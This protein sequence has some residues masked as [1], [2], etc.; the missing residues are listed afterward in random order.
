M[1]AEF[2]TF[3]RTATGF[4]PHSYQSAL[5]AEGLPTL[6]EAPTGAGK[7]VAAVLPWLYRRLVAAPGATPRRLVFVLPRHSL[8]GQAFG[9]IGEWLERLGLT[10]EVGLHLLAG[11]AAQEGGWRRRP[12]RSAI[13]VGTHDMVLSRALM[14]GYA[15]ART[16]APVSYALLHA[17]AQWVFDEA[18][19]LGPGLST[20]RQLQLLRDELGTASATG[21]MWMSSVRGP[22]GL[23][24]RTVRAPDTTGTVRRIGRLDL[25]PG[26]YIAALAEAVTA[27]H[28]PGTRTVV[29]LNSPER[30]RAVHAGLAA[31][32]S[33]ALLLHP[34]FRAADLARVLAAAEGGHGLVLVATPALETGL[35]ISGRTLVTELAPWASLVQRAG[36]CN[37]HGEHPDGGDLLWCTPPEGGD[38]ATARWLTAHEGRAVTPGEL[39][40]ARVDTPPAPAGPGREDVLAL[41]DS[42]ADDS[43]ADDSPAA[44]TAAGVDHWIC[45]P[46]EAASLP[47][48]VAWRAL[49]CA[50]QG[51]DKSGED[52][53]GE[54]GPGED[55]PDPTGAE[56]C[57][58]PLGELRRL[59]AG[60]AWLRD[61]LDRRWRPARPEDLRPGVRLL[62]DA[63]TGGYLPDRGWTP[64][65]PA[66]VA[67]EAAASGHPAYGCT[68]W[69]GLDQHLQE[70]AQEA[71]ALLAALPAL[72]TDLWEA[73]VEAARFHDLGKCHDAFQE[74]LRAGRTDPPGGLLAK[75]KNGVGADPLPPYRSPRPHLR[76]ELVSA[77]LLWQGGHHPLVTY[78]AAAHHGHV[79]LTV[80]PRGDEAPLLLGVADGDRTPPIRLSTGEYFPART[81]HTAAFPAAW[82]ERA[83]S[84]RDTPGLGPFRLAF[85]ETLVR[86]ADWRASARHDGTLAPTTAPAG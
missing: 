51:E 1:T 61:A 15:D 28:V 41:F 35:D 82:T 76:H 54:D 52:G 22:G 64:D 21:T 75:S 73:V 16:M 7:T 58:V 8:A 38:A 49:E 44:D 42:P 55:E 11:A 9:R 81:L 14:R 10:G 84:L 78:L 70:T 83:L 69:V 31:R 32:G 86:V 50:G 26:R 4:T 12:E 79:R 65:S 5:A 59:P 71:Q 17:D 34:H 46:A 27:A 60:R 48:L 36:R 23:G 19:L 66:P 30:A 13:L 29:V 77:L 33:E 72:P 37:R 80:R 85:L 57:P 18:H 2:E 47:A 74:K 62:L 56:L 6:L 25:P 45:D 39:L 68:A 20:G 40:T 43:P 24:G 63:R 3:A 67:C 53:P